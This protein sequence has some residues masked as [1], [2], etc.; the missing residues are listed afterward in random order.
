MAAKKKIKEDIES[1]QELTGLVDILKEI[2]AAKFRKARDR[3]ER[4][5][6]F[7]DSFESFFRIVNLSGATHPFTTAGP[8]RMGIVMITSDHGFMGRLN[9]QVI[10]TA[11]DYR[12]GNSAELII[13]GQKGASF[14]KDMGEEF[15]FFTGIGE[16]NKHQL[17]ID[18]RDYIIRQ[19][20]KDKIGRTVLIYPEP[21]SFSYQKIK[22]INIF[23]CTD[24]FERKPGF[25][26]NDEKII[27]ESSLDKI[28]EYLAATWITHKF[29]EVFEDSKL[30]EF[31]ARTLSLENSYQ[32]LLKRDGFLHRQYN[33]SSHKLIDR[34][35]R[36][37]FGSTFLRK[38]KADDGKK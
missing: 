8:D 9:A 23:P 24:L 25:D 35:M 22:L 7:L 3:K 27:V 6:T 38:R 2:S 30:S 4:F 28:V 36:D 11:L 19:R 5:K 15:T 21:A 16:V 20:L 37:I 32:Q 33:Y 17:V 1:N 34:N 14:L 12:S 31:A 10:N 29:Y 13:L 18:I 26:F